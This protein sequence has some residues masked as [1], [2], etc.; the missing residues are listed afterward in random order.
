MD[1]TTTRDYDDELAQEAPL[2]P[3]LGRSG[4]TT[5]TADDFRTD[6]STPRTPN[7]GS[8]TP[9]TYDDELAQEAP[10]VPHLGRIDDQ[11]PTTDEPTADI[12]DR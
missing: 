7:G 4:G 2:V 6:L 9:Y 1:S 3:D 10:L 5:T 11:Q 8:T 12:H